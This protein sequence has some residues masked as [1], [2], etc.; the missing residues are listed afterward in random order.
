MNYINF[1]N[2]R[3]AA[4]IGWQMI[5]WLTS[6]ILPDINNSDSPTNVKL[7]C[8]LYEHHLVSMSWFRSTIINKQTLLEQ[9]YQLLKWPTLKGK[10][11]GHIRTRPDGLKSEPGKKKSFHINQSP[12]CVEKTHCNV[13]KYLCY[14]NAM[15]SKYREY[16]HRWSLRKS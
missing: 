14:S 6:N 2:T 12:A 3:L 11:R 1:T 9:V 5:L 4:I 8:S 13:K 7:P 15:P 10:S 16:H